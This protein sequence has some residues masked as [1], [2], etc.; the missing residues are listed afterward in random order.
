MSRHHVGKETNH[1]RKR[2]GKYS[3]KLY[4]RHYRHRISLKEQRHIRPENLFPIF[5]VAE[6]VDGQHRAYGKEERYVDVSRHI[7]T[8]GEYRNESYQITCEDKEEHRKQIRGIPTVMLFADRSLYDIVVYRHHQHL[9]HSHKTTRGCAFC[10]ALP[11]PPC[12]R[13]P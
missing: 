5:L 3:E 1:Q 7:R 9:H 2:F 10:V 4:H 8:A 6:Q 12:T 11:V 13:T